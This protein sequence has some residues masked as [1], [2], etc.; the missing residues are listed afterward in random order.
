MRNYQDN[1]DT[2]VS[3]D[4]DKMEEYVADVKN[5][6]LIMFGNSVL[7]GKSL[8]WVETYWNDKRPLQSEM[9]ERQNARRGLDGLRPIDGVILG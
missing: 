3:M 5:V 1:P 9:G 7:A 8:D 6:P 2:E 4:Q